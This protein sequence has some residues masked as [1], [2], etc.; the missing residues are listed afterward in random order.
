MTQ[1]VLY[2]TT[3][4]CAQDLFYAE[5]LSLGGRDDDAC[6]DA[7]ALKAAQLFLTPMEDGEVDASPEQR[8]HG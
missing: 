2:T 8:G 3:C 5:K 4:L 6:G 7:A 1:L